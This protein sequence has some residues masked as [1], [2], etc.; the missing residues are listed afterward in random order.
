MRFLQTRIL[1]D[2]MLNRHR[3]SLTLRFSGCEVVIVEL[4]SLK[5]GIFGLKI[6]GRQSDGKLRSIRMFRVS[7]IRRFF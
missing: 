3:V 5:W 2:C 6:V 1:V 7:N 4:I